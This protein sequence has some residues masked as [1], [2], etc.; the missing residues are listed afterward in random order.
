MEVGEGGLQGGEQLL[1]ALKAGGLSGTGRVAD[2]VC[3]DHLV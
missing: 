2:D 3:G 1:Y